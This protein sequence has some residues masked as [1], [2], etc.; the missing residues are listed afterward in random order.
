MSPPSFRHDSARFFSRVSNWIRS[1]TVR[2]GDRRPLLIWRIGW[3]VPKWWEITHDGQRVGWSIMIPSPIPIVD[4]SKTIHKNDAKPGVD[5][6]T[7]LPLLRKMSQ[8]NG[9]LLC[10][11]KT[12]DV[13][14]GLHLPKCDESLR[15]CL[16][17]AVFTKNYVFR[18]FRNVSKVS[19]SFRY[20]SF[21]YV[22]FTYGF[23]PVMPF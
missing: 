20:W 15:D 4:D 12:D 14:I 9:K 10:F 6:W 16:M 2:G 21:D 11:M 19:E 5:Y 22:I 13:T 7:S 3:K 18:N 1:Q 23:G 17:L 8:I